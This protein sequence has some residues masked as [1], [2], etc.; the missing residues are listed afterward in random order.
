MNN[1]VNN[2]VV[3]LPVKRLNRILS[4]L[5]EEMKDLSDDDR[6]F[7]IRWNIMH[8]YSSS[9]VAKIL[10]LRRGMDPELAGIAAALHDIGIVMTGRH[11]NHAE[12]GEKYIYEVIDRYN[13]VYRGNLPIITKDETY[14]IV[15]AVVQHSQKEVISDNLFVELLKD[16]DSIDRYLHGVKTEGAHLERC[17]KVLDELDIELMQ[18]DILH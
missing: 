11:E 13:S 4:M 7:P 17:N 14:L 6:D 12:A 1:E 10:A 15:N 16:V 18:E 2:D 9:Q 8:M 3:K 5:L